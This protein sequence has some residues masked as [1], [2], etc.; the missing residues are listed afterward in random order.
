[1]TQV[2]ASPVDLGTLDQVG[3]VVADM[4]EGVA[5]YAPLFGPFSVMDPGPMTWD[6]RGRP[7]QSHILVAFCNAGPI[8]IELIQ[9][10]AGPTPHKEFLDAGREGMHHLRYS[11]VDL[12]AALANA[13]TV[14]YHA[15]WHTRFDFGGGA[16]YLEREG[17]ALLI[18]LYQPLPLGESQAQGG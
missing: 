18:E 10:V 6:Y 13:A 1:M 8:E 17:D 12:D 2:P 7:E 11:V 14:G 15:I 5:R 3:F 4:D 9:W 16:A